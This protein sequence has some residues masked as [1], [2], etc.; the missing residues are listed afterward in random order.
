MSADGFW[1]GLRDGEI[2]L[3]EIAASR[4]GVAAGDT[5][6]LPTVAGPKAVPGGWNLSCHE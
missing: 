3:S 6:E 4:L 2:G 1:Q 5:V